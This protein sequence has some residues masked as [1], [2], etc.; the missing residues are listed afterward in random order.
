MQPEGWIKKWH[1]KAVYTVTKYKVSSA[2]NCKLKYL[3][4]KIK[5]CYI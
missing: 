1:K 2:E 4:I 5:T 3:F